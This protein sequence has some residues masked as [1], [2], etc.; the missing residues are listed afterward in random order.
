[1]TELALE[2]PERMLDLDAH[3]G[4]DPFGL[5]VDGVELSALVQILQMYS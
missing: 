2:N 3:H 1:M 5:L 4:D